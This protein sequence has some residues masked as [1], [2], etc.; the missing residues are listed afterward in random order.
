[1][2]QRNATET[3]NDDQGAAPAPGSPRT[4]LGRVV[5]GSLAVGFVAAAI[6]PFL[7]VGTVDAN[8]STAMALFGWALGWALLAGLSTRFTDQPQR[9]AVVPAIFMAVA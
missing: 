2:T 6:L 5:I 3:V 7:T 1:M 8:F 9:C 4:H